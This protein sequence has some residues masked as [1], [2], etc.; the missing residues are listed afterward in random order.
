MGIRVFLMV[1][2]LLSPIFVA[3]ILWPGLAR[4]DQPLFYWVAAVGAVIWT[5]GA[6]H[7]LLAFVLACIG[8]TPTCSND[9][10]CAISAV[11]D[12]LRWWYFGS[13]ALLSLLA[14]AFTKYCNR[15]AL[16]R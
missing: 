2:A 11:F 5:V 1:L 9:Y 10:D 4:P 15:I 8:L 6:V 16:D 13:S 3:R 7:L 14:Y 12:G